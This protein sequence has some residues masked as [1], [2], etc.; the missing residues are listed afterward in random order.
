MHNQHTAFDG[1]G[2]NGRA[3]AALVTAGSTG[4]DVSDHDTSYQA[5][6]RDQIAKLVADSLPDGAYINLGIGMPTKVGD[7]LPSDREFVLHSENGILGM[8]S[9]A[10][11]DSADPD[12]INASR[13]PVSLLKGASI[14]EH[15]NSFAMMRGGH[16]D[17]SILGGFQ[18]AANGDLANWMT[19]ADNAIPAVGGAM[20][21]VVGAK[22]LI[23]MMEHTT[24]EGQPK[25]LAQ[26]TYP[27]TGLGVVDWVYTDLAVLQPRD[28]VFDVYAMVDGLSMDV[29][30]GR[31]DAPLAVGSPRIIKLDEKGLP[32]YET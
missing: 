20:D 10:S 32:Y 22:H 2:G 17:Y 14:T 1:S 11:G 21:L 25:L 7:Y 31:T 18:V 27:V 3:A 28:G 23:V 4:A 8:G 13:V 24:R 19:D 26:C 12:L 5:L 6:N 16:L 9:A 30:Q 15:T 29:L